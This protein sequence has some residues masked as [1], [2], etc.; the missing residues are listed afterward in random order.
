MPISVQALLGDWEGYRYDFH[1]YD[2]QPAIHLQR[3]RESQQD[4]LR[5]TWTG[6]IAGLTGAWTGGKSAWVLAM[7]Q[8][9]NQG[10]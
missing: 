8:V 5:L 2:G 4:A 9:H 10:T 1:W 6:I 7:S 3:Y